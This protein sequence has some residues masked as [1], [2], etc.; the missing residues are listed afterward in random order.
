MRRHDEAPRY[1]IRD[2]RAVIPTNDVQAKVDSGGA[3]GGGQQV[4][5]VHVQNVGI[6]NDSWIPATEQGGVPPM[7]GR[8]ASVEQ[9]S[10]RQHEHAG[11]NRDKSGTAAVSCP[12]CLDQIGGRRLFRAAPSGYDDCACLSQHAETTRRCELEPTDCS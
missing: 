4:A 6:D 11:T 7:R 3:A 10:R 9:P 2:M 1:K 5:F 12:E 8:A